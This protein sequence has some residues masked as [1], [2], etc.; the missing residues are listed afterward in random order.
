LQALLDWE[1][2]VTDWPF[3]QRTVKAYYTT[4]YVTKHYPRWMV[5][6]RAVSERTYGM[7][8]FGQRNEA[9]NAVES[10]LLPL[11]VSFVRRDTREF[12]SVENGAVFSALDYARLPGLT[13]R[14]VTPE[15]LAGAWNRDKD[16]YAVRFVSGNT[17]YAAIAATEQTAVYGWW[18]SRE[19]YIDRTRTPAE[20][21]KVDL[22]VDGRRATFFLEDSVVHL[23]A[24][25]DV[26][27][28]SQ[29]TLTNL[30]QR[31]SAGEGIVIG[32]GS[33]RQSVQAGET[34]RLP[35]VTW[36]LYDEV[37]YLP[38]RSTTPLQTTIQDVVQP[39]NPERAVFSIFTDH[40]RSE[41][42]LAF[43]WAV[44]PGASEE[45]MRR[46][47]VQRPYRIVENTKRVQA[48]EAEGGAWLGAVFHEAGQVTL[49]D[50]TVVSV[51]RPAAVVVERQGGTIRVSAADPF[52]TDGELSV[53]VG[54]KTATLSLPGGEHRGSTV[55]GEAE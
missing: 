26:R 27:H 53:A 51:S 52:E 6:L 24:G 4:D 45:T 17:P 13:T 49:G 33:E 30:E 31:R 36:V 2:G 22:M 18:Q 29:P 46:V 35:G 11:G 16:G 54:G 1:P 38:P 10:V 23:G 8:T 39:G 12:Q 25:F 48:I 43:D 34:V 32:V 3:P 20:R 40:G 9:R 47:G 7:E 44:Y 42:D 5:S 41:A 55:R 37:G 21:K 28:D 15:Q 50:G 14:H 19:V